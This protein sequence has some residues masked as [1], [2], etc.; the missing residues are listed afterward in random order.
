VGDG[1]RGV[2]VGLGQD[3][4]ELVAAVASEQVGAARRRPAMQRDMAQHGVT[5]GVAAGVVVVLELADV[6]D[7]RM[8]VANLAIAHNRSPKFASRGRCLSDG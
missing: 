7:E 2:Q 4:D 1:G 6:E 3:R 5:G 8:R